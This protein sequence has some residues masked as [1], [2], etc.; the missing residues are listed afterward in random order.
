MVYYKAKLLLTPQAQ[1]RHYIKSTGA[2][3]ELPYFRLNERVFKGV[4]EYL[5][6]TGNRD[7]A[8]LLMKEYNG[9]RDFLAGYTN[10]ATIKLNPSPLYLKSVARPERMTE[11]LVETMLSGIQDISGLAFKRR[12]GLGVFIGGNEGTGVAGEWSIKKVRNVLD[13]WKDETADNSNK[14]CL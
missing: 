3:V 12:T 4:F 2:P 7:V 8:E 6:D 11:S 13:G 10:E 5:K 9:T 14:R 1:L